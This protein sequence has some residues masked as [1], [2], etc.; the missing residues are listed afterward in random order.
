MKTVNRE[1]IRGM[2][3]MTCRHIFAVILAAGLLT[4]IAAAENSR[5]SRKYM[6]RRMRRIKRKL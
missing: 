1:N 5:E 4:G 3:R 2:L 6:M